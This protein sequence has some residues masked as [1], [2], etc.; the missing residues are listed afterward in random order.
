MTPGG[1][2]QLE[3]RVAQQRSS[4]PAFE[5]TATDGA[6]GRLIIACSRDWT[7]AFDGKNSAKWKVRQV[8]RSFTR[9]RTF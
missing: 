4:D 7:V 6:G 2:G 8:R 9:F 1:N 3:T 5:K